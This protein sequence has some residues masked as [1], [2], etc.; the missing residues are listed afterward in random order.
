MSDKEIS[1]W[2]LCTLRFFGADEANAHRIVAMF[3]EA[4]NQQNDIHGSIK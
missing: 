3:I 2:L 1:D 4:V